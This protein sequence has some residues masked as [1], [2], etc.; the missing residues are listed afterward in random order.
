MNII[1]QIALQLGEEKVL[2]LLVKECAELIQAAMKLRRV[3]NGKNPTPVTEEE[4]KAALLEEIADVSICLTALGVDSG[5][6]RMKIQ[7][8]V[9]R[10]TRRWAE[11]L[12]IE[13]EQ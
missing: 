2:R 12:G 10:K 9:D 5:L 7:E 4:A 3:R 1:Q 6:N 8:I 13:V 11:S